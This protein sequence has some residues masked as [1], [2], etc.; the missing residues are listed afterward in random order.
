[1]QRNDSK[2]QRHKGDDDAIQNASRRVGV[3][4]SR[5][6]FIRE[7]TR[8]SQ[9]FTRSIPRDTLTLSHATVVRDFETSCRENAIGTNIV[10]DPRARSI[11]IVRERVN[12][13]TIII[14]KGK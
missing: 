9:K 6:N 10:F 7:A 3:E 8:S 12:V 4:G 13:T 2:R 14:E 1:M 11:G 5:I